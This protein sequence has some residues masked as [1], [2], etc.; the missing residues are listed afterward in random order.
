MP[1]YYHHPLLRSQ[2]SSKFASYFNRLQA[3]LGLIKIIFNSHRRQVRNSTHYLFTAAAAAATAESTHNLNHF[4]FPTPL[5]ML[6]LK[7]V[8]S[9]HQKLQHRVKE[10]H[11]ITTLRFVQSQALFRIEIG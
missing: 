10:L 1:C 2:I 4:L 5:P 8:E 11:I 9:T 6:L 3:A 7:F